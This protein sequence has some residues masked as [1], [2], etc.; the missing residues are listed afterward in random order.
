VTRRP[1]L[2]RGEAM[3]DRVHGA[4]L[5]ADISGFTP[6]TEAL[7]AE[8]GAHR[9]AEELTKHL[10]RVFHTLIEELHRFGG[11]VIY[12]QR[13]LHHVLSSRPISFHS[14]PVSSFLKGLVSRGIRIRVLTNSL[15]SNDV[16]AAFA[17]YSKVRHL[18]VHQ[19]TTRWGTVA[20]S[21]C[22]PFPA[23]HSTL[24]MMPVSV[25]ALAET[26]THRRVRRG[27]QHDPADRSATAAAINPRDACC[28]QE[29]LR[30]QS[31]RTGRAIHR[32]D[33]R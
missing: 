1:A 8:L 26:A 29:A 4:A 28:G 13:R 27:G 14:S 17:G 22:R 25:G 9:G 32:R 5:F 24:T 21:P 18:Q 30:V 31:T 33:Q 2:V 6:L 20:V 12:F 3:P 7:S 16:L 15:A 19:I 23:Y 10:N 11:E